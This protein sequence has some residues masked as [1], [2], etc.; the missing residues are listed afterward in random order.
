MDSPGKGDDCPL[1]TNAVATILEVQV[2]VKDG[3][4]AGS[5]HS[6]FEVSFLYTSEG[7]STFQPPTI[8]S[9]KPNQISSSG[10]DMVKVVGTSLD[11]LFNASTIHVQFGS[12]ESA[13]G[14]I[15]SDT[16]II[17]KAPPF[18][19]RSPSAEGTHGY[20]VLVRVTNLVD[21]WSNAVQLFVEPSAAVFSIFPDAG[22]ACGGTTVSVEGKGFAPSV[23]LACIFGKGEDAVT[24][25]ADWRSPQVVQCVAP[26]WPLSREEEEV[27]VPLAVANSEATSP[28][29]FRFTAPVVVTTISPATDPAE[30]GANVS[31]NGVNFNRYDLACVVGSNE[32]PAIV[33]S[34]NLLRCILPPG[35]VPPQRYFKIEVVANRKYAIAGV[36]ATNTSNQSLDAV[37]ETH[38]KSGST[39]V[40]LP[41][42]RGHQ[43]WLDQTD[44]SNLDHPIALSP[45]P[46]GT[47]AA[48]AE[49]W[50]KGVQHLSS[51][52]PSAPYKK[53]KGSTGAGVLSFTV[54]LD[55]P[56][57]LYLVS[58]KHAV[59]HSDVQAVI[60]DGVVNT[61]ITVVAA[62]GSF[63]DPQPSPF[64]CVRSVPK[65]NRGSRYL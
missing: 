30:S 5:E 37:G 26:P 55:A 23:S 44:E 17:F 50:T 54:P 32:V 58:D 33:E 21:F 22:P 3:T 14:E 28:F 43:Y 41:L 48:G 10:G 49:M 7:H 9:I 46:E 1:H 6:I 39:S 15:V 29:F 8:V 18:L 31:V 53:S 40:V 25:H 34:D 36:D 45:S 38:E 13:I 47:S 59:I 35:G 16:E 57:V 12:G 64:R 62:F 52:T 65:R 27:V 63:C 19:P 60:T 51:L 61:S 2:R 4:A 42:V 11:S 20:F 24:V 56:D